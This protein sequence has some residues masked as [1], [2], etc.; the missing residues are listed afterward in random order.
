MT[1]QP[2]QEDHKPPSAQLMGPLQSLSPYNS[3][4]PLFN[5]QDLS[6]TSHGFSVIIT[7]VFQLG[8]RIPYCTDKEPRAQRGPVSCP[9]AHS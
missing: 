1:L 7:T 3:R 2:S 8:V 4:F 5:A 6:S 9:K